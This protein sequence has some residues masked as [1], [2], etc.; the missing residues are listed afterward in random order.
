MLLYQPPDGYCY[1]SD[2]I[3]LYDFIRSF[4]PRGKLLDLGCGMGVISL[5]LARDFPLE[6]ALSE[7]QPEI[8]EYARHNFAIHGM[9]PELYHGDFLEREIEG[10]FDFVVSNP[11][12]YDPGGTQSEEKRLNC[13]RYA[14]HLPLEKMVAKVRRILKPRGRFLFCYDARQTDRVLHR[15]REEKFAIETLRFV[16]PKVDREATLVLVAARTH[17]RAFCRVVPP[18]IVFDGKGE[19]GPE[20]WEAF[21]H[22]DTHSIKGVRDIDIIEYKKGM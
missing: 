21:R 6:V 15:L 10:G 16:H 18:L 11:P 14:H 19:Y 5:L 4:S 2:S 3:F 9:E 12:F 20:A 8:L 1:N 13:S 17:S 22:A 7:K